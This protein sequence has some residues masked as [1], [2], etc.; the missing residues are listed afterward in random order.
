MGDLAFLVWRADSDRFR[1]ERGA[2]TFLIRDGR[3]VMQT[4][5]YHLLDQD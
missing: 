3:I 5:H 2:D 4:I 1:I